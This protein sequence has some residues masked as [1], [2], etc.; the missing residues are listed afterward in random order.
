MVL[1]APMKSTGKI[2]GQN[3]KFLKWMENNHNQLNIKM[4]HT[5][6]AAFFLPVKIRSD[7][8]KPW[9]VKEKIPVQLILQ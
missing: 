2:A 8:L 5:F 7:S 6:D 1:N 9:G 4:L 3:L